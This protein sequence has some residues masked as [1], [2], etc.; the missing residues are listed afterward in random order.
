[1]RILVI[2]NTI[3]R[4]CWGSPE[5]ARF[6]KLFPGATVFTR[7]APEGDLPSSPVDFDRVIVSGSKTAATDDGPWISALLEFIRRTVD[8]GRPYLGVCYGHQSLVRALGG[9]EVVR[10][11][12]EAEFGWVRV[13]QI[14]SEASPLFKGLAKEFYSFG[15]HFDEVHQLPSDLKLLARSELCEV[16][17]CQLQG[18]AVFGIQFHPE[19]NL[20]E[21]E[22]ALAERKKKG[23][24]KRLL[25][26]DRGSELY[27]AVVGESIFRNFLNS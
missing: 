8:A 1:M 3:D 23:T 22:T 10:R 17:A 24:P 25:N 20:A 9:K 5:L 12:A 4:N 7:R 15:S 21:A 11:A 2:D 18:K 13:E 19:K 6:G 27:D 16:Q 14:G 26:A